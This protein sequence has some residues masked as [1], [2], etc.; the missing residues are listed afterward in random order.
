MMT[1]W[2]KAGQGDERLKEMS[3][4]HTKSLAFWRHVEIYF[5]LLRSA[6]FQKL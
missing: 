6:K 5:I 4:V 2:S 3:L 1:H